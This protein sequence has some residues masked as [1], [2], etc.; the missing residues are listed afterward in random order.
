MRA[1]FV[2]CLA[3]VPAALRGQGFPD[4]SA[5]A[6]RY[7]P[8]LNVRVRPVDSVLR[9]QDTVRIEYTVTNT[10]AGA[11]ALCV[12]KGH[13]VELVLG[14][15]TLRP[16]VLVD[17]E[18]CTRAD[19]L[20]PSQSVTSERALALPELQVSGK[21]WLTSWIDIVDPTDCGVFGCARA[22]IS[23]HPVVVRLVGR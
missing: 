12:G 4:D 16:F 1:F 7:L 21:A 19:T 8:A 18:S 6:R 15:D 13:G 9:S 10:S 5:A 11:V 22:V 23:A 2:L 17:H 14:A 20:L 3:V